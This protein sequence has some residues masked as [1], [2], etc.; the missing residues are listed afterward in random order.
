MK[1]SLVTDLQFITG[2]TLSCSLHHFKNFQKNRKSHFVLCPLCLFYLYTERRLATLLLNGRIGLS[3][4]FCFVI[5]YLKRV[6]MT[7]TL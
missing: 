6:D 1:D 2:F 5:L 4:L 3:F 7:A